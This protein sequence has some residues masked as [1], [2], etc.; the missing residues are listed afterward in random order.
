VLLAQARQAAVGFAFEEPAIEVRGQGLVARP[1]QPRLAVVGEGPERFAFRGGGPPE[2]GFVGF[3]DDRVDRFG[4]QGLAHTGV[5]GNGE[6]GGLGEVRKRHMLEVAARI[7]PDADAGPVQ[8]T[9]PVST[10]AM[11]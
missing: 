2:A 1:H 11:V 3:G 10:V 8:A 4:H 6:H 9:A 7:D 5:V